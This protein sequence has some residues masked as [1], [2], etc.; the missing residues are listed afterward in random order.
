MTRGR[1]AHRPG[2]ALTVRVTLVAIATPVL[3]RFVPFDRLARALGAGRPRLS[4]AGTDVSDAEI[5]GLV[6][7][8]LHRLGGPWRWTCLKRATALFHLLRA[9]GRTVEL[10]IGVRRADDGELLAHAWLV[11]DDRPYLEPHEENPAIHQVIASF[12]ESR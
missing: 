5:A 1:A 6:D 2:P 7:G 12:P 3:L 8:V 11:Q 10:R 9:A 4:S